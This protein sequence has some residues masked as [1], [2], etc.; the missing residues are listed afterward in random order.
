M[1]KSEIKGRSL[2]GIAAGA[3]ALGSIA[4]ATTIAYAAPREVTITV[5]SLKAIDKADQFSKG[6]FYA[7][8][9]IDGEAQS[10]Q[11]IK[12]SD[13]D[14]PGWKLSKKVKGGDV[15]VTLEVFDKDVA[16]DDPIDI[17]RVDNKRSLDFTVNTKSCRISGFSSGYSCGAVISRAGAEKKAAEIKFKVNVK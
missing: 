6:D 10:T 7:R 15:K 12:Q 5:I 3:L 16:A 8:A 1:P 4:V 2:R 14:K 13:T 17:N 9:T 11:P